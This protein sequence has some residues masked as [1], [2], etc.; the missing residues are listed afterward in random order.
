M[1]VEKT[2]PN[3]FVKLNWPKSLEKAEELSVLCKPL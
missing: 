1:P 2:N 3:S